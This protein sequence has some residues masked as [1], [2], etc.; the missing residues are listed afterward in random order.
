MAKSQ[1]AWVIESWRERWVW[2]F[3][4]TRISPLFRAIELWAIIPL[5]AIP[6][7]GAFWGRSF[8]LKKKG[9]NLH[10]RQSEK[11][12]I[13]FSFS[14]FYGRNRKYHFR[15]GNYSESRDRARLVVF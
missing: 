2:P 11:I 4:K 10:E 13:D 5:G 12:F 6:E 14:F 3:P 8:C 1:N 9:L 15:Q 7:R